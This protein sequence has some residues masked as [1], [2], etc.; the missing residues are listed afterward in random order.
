MTY[1]ATTD[2]YWADEIGLAEDLD[3]HE[4]EAEK[5]CDVFAHGDDAAVFDEGWGQAFVESDTV[6]E[7]RR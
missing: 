3:P 2:E 7:V 4:V 6:V 5:F 1:E